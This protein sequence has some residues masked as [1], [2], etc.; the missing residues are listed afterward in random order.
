MRNTCGWTGL[1]LAA[2]VL[3]VGLAGASSASAATMTSNNQ[4]S[5]SGSI[6]TTGIAG[7]NVISFSSV[8]VGSFQAN[9]PD[10]PPANFS[11]G[12]FLVGA[13]PAGVS[14]V[15]TDTP[16]SITYIS[17][18][19]NDETPS[20]NETPITLTGVLNGVVT[21][22]NYSSVTATFEPIDKT[23]FR[24]G[25]FLNTLTVPNAVWLAPSTTNGGKNSAQGK[26]VA[27]A[28]PIPEPTSIAVFLAA[29]AGLGLRHKYRRRAA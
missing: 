27:E 11:L 8:G 4:Y 5:T 29:I 7:A 14:T 25:D 12:E 28:S 1:R 21:G 26:L 16:F 18:Q 6:G 13:L 2:C 17:Q 24:T 23:V 9:G 10:D 22:S 15:Y 3:A 19:V 20:V